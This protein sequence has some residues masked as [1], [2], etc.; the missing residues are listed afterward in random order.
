MF[1][2]LAFHTSTALLSLFTV[3]YLINIC[4]AAPKQET[5]S[6]TVTNSSHNRTN[7]TFCVVSVL[8]K[9]LFKNLKSV[10]Y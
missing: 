4:M 1:I 9:L 10:E 8:T 7:Y 3:V 6:T 2:A 5:S